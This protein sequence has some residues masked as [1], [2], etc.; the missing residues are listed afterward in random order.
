MKFSIILAHIFELAFQQLTDQPDHRLPA[1][2]NLR[3]A[4]NQ[5]TQEGNEDQSFCPPYKK[6]SAGILHD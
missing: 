2:E 1:N 5:K 6:L 4:I 3:M